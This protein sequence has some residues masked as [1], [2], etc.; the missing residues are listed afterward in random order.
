MAIIHIDNAAD[1]KAGDTV[2]FSP[3]GMPFF[4]NDPL[5]LDER[6]GVVGFFYGENEDFFPVLTPGKE[7][8]PNLVLVTATRD[9]VVR[10]NEENIG[11]LIRTAADLPAL[12]GVPVIIR[13]P[14]YGD[15]RG[16]ASN[17]DIDGYEWVRLTNGAGYGS[18]RFWQSD[19]YTIYH[20]VGLDMEYNF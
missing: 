7:F 10:E 3:F 13:H 15:Y 1:L 9:V 19:N 2:V 18:F 14:E 20:A 17:D 5:K 12:Y 11:R 6:D 16:F 8:I 4:K